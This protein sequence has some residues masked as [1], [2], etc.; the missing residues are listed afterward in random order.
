M[1]TKKLR[2]T[3]RAHFPADSSSWGLILNTRRKLVQSLE[4]SAGAAISGWGQSSH[5]DAGYLDR[6]EVRMRALLCQY[7]TYFVLIAQIYSL[8]QVW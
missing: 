7:S 3:G 4:L 1:I 5:V 6:T 8:K 2:I